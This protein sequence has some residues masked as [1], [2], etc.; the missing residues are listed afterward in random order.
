MASTLA[1]TFGDVDN[2]VDQRSSLI[3][4][5]RARF[6]NGGEEEEAMQEIEQAADAAAELNGEMV[7]QAPDFSSDALSLSAPIGGASA[8][9]CKEEASDDSIAYLSDFLFAHAEEVG[10]SDEANSDKASTGDR[11]ADAFARADRGLDARS[12]VIDALKVQLSRSSA[13]PKGAPSTAPPVHVG[14]ELNPSVPGASPIIDLEMDPPDGSQS[15]VQPPAPVPPASLPVVPPPLKRMRRDPPGAAPPPPPVPVAPEPS[16]QQAQIA[17]APKASTQPSAADLT[18]R[19]ANSAA[20][21][22]ELAARKAAML[23]R[24][25][26]TAGPSEAPPT[27][28]K[29]PAPGIAPKAMPNTPGPAPP[30]SA[31]CPNGSSPEQYEAYRRKCWEQYYEYCEVW[32]K[33]Y[34]QNQAEQTGKGVKGGKAK[35]KLR[36]AGGVP[37]TGP[38]FSGLTLPPPTMGK[39][40]MAMPPLAGLPGAGKGGPPALQLSAPTLGAIPPGL[41]GGITSGS[42]AIHAANQLASAKAGGAGQDVRPVVV[43][44]PARVPVRAPAPPADEDINSILLGL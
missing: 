14:V 2:G 25:Q 26:E 23:R 22:A 13:I 37:G 7:S 4:A 3:A 17:V 20:E 18:A 38:D 9:L 1:S 44:P 27:S 12:K 31:D 28:A 8:G 36:P 29:A 32:K 5:L 40:Q 11:L 42:L 35:G 43:P 34:S 15:Q 33:Y 10:I 30:A 41:P 39:G 21:A 19:A 16:T 24:L 6:G